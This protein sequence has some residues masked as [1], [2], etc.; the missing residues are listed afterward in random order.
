METSADVDETETHGQGAEDAV[1]DHE[2]GGGAGS[3]VDLVGG[4]AEDPGGEYEEED[5]DADYLVGLVDLGVLE[6]VRLK[7]I[8]GGY[9]GGTY[10]LFAF[11]GCDAD[12]DTGDD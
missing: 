6:F 8:R 10:D 4:H 7:G 9:G 11:A 12:G 3:F 2:F 1:A 5:D